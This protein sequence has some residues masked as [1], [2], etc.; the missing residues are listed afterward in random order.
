MPRIE[1]T[2]GFYISAGGDDK[3]IYLVTARHVVLPKNKDT[4]VEWRRKNTSEPRYDV[5]VLG[6]SGFNEKLSAISD[7]IESQRNTI[8]RIQNRIDF[9]AGRNDQEAERV[10]NDAGDAWRNV[11][12][13]RGLLSYATTSWGGPIPTTASLVIWSGPLP[14]SYLRTLGN[15]HKISL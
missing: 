13:S 12:Q 10:H 8:K 2:G 4:N 3:K 6:N 14:S 15:I 9:V 1:G 11:N 7:E 5:V